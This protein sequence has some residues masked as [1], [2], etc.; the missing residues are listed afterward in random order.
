VQLNEDKIEKLLQQRSDA[1]ANK[2]YGTAD[3]IAATL[4]EEGICYV[5]EKKEW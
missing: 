2:D 1:K 5:D 3:K 4:Q